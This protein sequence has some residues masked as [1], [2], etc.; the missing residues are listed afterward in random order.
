[1]KD[2]AAGSTQ[3]FDRLFGRYGLPGLVGVIDVFVGVDDWLMELLEERIADGTCGDE[4]F[5]GGGEE[6][7]V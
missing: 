5:A 2:A 4:F 3:N 1:M 7:F 6:I